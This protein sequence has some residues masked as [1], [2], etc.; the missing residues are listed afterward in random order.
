MATWIQAGLI[1][2]HEYYVISFRTN[3]HLKG[4]NHQQHCFKRERVYILSLAAWH[5]ENMNSFKGDHQIAFWAWAIQLYVKIPFLRLCQR[6]FYWSRNPNI[7]KISCCFLGRFL[8]HSSSLFTHPYLCAL[9]PIISML[10]MAWQQESPFAYSDQSQNN[11]HTYNKTPKEQH[12]AL[13][14]RCLH[15]LNW[16][17]ILPYLQPV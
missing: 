9:V 14:R 2:I 7:S 10:P 17:Y 4:R 16:Y 13:P 11:S 1:I 3:H 15:T 5:I 6:G 12:D 8:N